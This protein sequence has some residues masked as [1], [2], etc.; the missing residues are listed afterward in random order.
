M[1]DGGQHLRSDW[2][3]FAGSAL[4]SWRPRSRSPFGWR[5]ARAGRCLGD[6]GI[7]RRG[8]DRRALGRE[9]DRRLGGRRRDGDNA[10]QTPQTVPFAMSPRGSERAAADPPASRSGGGAPADKSA[11]QGPRIHHADPVD[12]PRLPRGGTPRLRRCRGDGV[13]FLRVGEGSPCHD[14]GGALRVTDGQS[15]EGSATVGTSPA[16]DAPTFTGRRHARQSRRVVT[17]R[18]CGLGRAGQSWVRWV[19]VASGAGP[20]PTTRWAPPAVA[21]A[22]EAIAGRPQ[23]SARVRARARLRDPRDRRGAA[24]GWRAGSP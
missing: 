15:R 7:M 13:S 20:P 6:E 4:R 14:L 17:G 23:A 12:P 2:R 22:R 3:P 19:V 21:R 5:L 8:R 10:G 1:K 24:Y 18:P 9:E 11:T 16:I